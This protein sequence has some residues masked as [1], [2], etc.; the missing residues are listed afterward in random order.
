V[1][2][3]HTGDVPYWLGTQDALNMFRTTRNWTKADRA[4]MARMQSMIISFAQ[5][6]APD[7]TWPA[8]DAKHPRVMELDEISR[9]IN[10]PHYGALG[11]LSS[12][13]APVRSNEPRK[14][15]D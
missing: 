3:Y 7:A 1:G 13:S 15:R 5:G 14:P 2:A 8:F 9:V 11:L 10:W 6:G 12:A 4:L